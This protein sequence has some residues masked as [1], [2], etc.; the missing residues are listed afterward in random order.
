V[1]N[2]QEDGVVV[3]GIPAISH[4]IWLRSS[5]AFAKLPELL[6]RVR[7]LEKKLAE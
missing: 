4:R 2:S 3:A 5:A 6:K 1:H 7:N